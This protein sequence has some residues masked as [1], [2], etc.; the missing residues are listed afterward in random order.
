MAAMMGGAVHMEAQKAVQDH[1]TGGQ[2]HE[3]VKSSY[4]MAHNFTIQ[5]SLGVG[6]FLGWHL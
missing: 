6:E 4:Q 2:F 1:L 5:G 3:A